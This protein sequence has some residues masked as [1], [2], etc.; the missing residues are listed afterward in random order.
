MP[1]KVFISYDHD[2]AAQVNGFRGLAANPNHPLELVD[3]SLAE[4]VVDGAG[5]VIRYVPMDPRSE[6]VRLQIRACFDQCSRMVVLIGDD[7]HSSMWVDWEIEDFYRRKQL[8]SSDPSRRIIGMRLKG[9][10]GGGPRA[11]RGRSAGTIAWDLA[12]FDRW[13]AQSV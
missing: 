10:R 13:L 12:A 2:D 8:V 1:A 11:L 9:C 4:A 7:T 6:P 3:G 5:K